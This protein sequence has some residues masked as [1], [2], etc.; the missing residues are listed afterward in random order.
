M[1]NFVEKPLSK[2][3]TPLDWWRDNEDKYPS[4]ANWAKSYLC[5]PSTST[6]S[7]C[8]FSAAGNI[9]CK[10]RASL[11]PEHVDMLTFS[12]LNIFKCFGYLYLGHLKRF[13]CLKSE[14]TF[15]LYFYNVSIIFL[16]LSFWLCFWLFMFWILLKVLLLNVTLPSEE[17]NAGK[18]A[19]EKRGTQRRTWS[20]C[21]EIIQRGIREVMNQKK[22]Y[23]HKPEK[24][25]T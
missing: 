12:H 21:D 24:S 25:N 17:T 1:A 14:Q 18:P 8:L 23:I 3:E 22:T 6:P 16:K 2:E 9:A 5:M 4:L 15:V 13:Y 10:K 20:E 19:A 11:S 7:E